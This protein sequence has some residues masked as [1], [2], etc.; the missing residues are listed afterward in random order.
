MKGRAWPAAPPLGI[1]STRPL[2]RVRVQRD[3]RV[4]LGIEG[5]D[6]RK[7]QLTSRSDVSSPVSKAALMSAMEALASSSA[8]DRHGADDSKPQGGK[9]KRRAL[10]VHGPR[11]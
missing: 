8:R 3:D 9:A 1:E 11:R 10:H 2:E 5:F 6:T 7:R 4:Q